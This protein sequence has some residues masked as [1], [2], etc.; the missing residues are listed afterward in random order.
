M[1]FLF[2]F[3]GSR[4]KGHDGIT[5]C[6][7]G[8]WEMDKSAKIL[9]F[10]TSEPSEERILFGLHAYLGTLLLNLRGYKMPVRCL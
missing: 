7:R 6:S 8:T 1:A 10:R 4:G 5:C 9:R 3:A 2:R